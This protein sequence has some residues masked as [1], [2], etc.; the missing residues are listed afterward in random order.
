MICEIEKEK[1]LKED[2][3]TIIHRF[4][5]LIQEQKKDKEKLKQLL[6]QQNKQIKSLEKRKD[7]LQE[8]NAKIY[9]DFNYV[10]DR[11]F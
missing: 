10:I 5:K 4:K 3:F 7:V 8:D 2:I 9:E 11:D 1:C 6:C